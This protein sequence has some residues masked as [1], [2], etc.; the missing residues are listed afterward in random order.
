MLE[1]IH[2]I[3]VKSVFN[4]QERTKEFNFTIGPTESHPGRADCA[5]ACVSDFAPRD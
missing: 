5:F 3:D 2:R 1:A 4:F